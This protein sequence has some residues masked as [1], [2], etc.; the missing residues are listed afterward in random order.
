MEKH[1]VEK[2]IKIF[3]KERKN[4]NTI[5]DDKYEKEVINL[6]ELDKLNLYVLQAIRDAIVCKMADMTW[7][8]EKNRFFYMSITSYVTSTIDNYIVKAGGEV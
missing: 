3:E 8:D 7:K 2:L 4:S 5:T 6:F 1:Y